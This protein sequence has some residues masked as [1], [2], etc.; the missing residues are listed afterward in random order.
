MIEREGD[1]IVLRGAVTVYELR[2][3]L[4]SGIAEIENGA[5]IVDLGALEQAD[6]SAIGM[7]IEW[8]RVSKRLGRELA[9]VN[10][11][12]GLASLIRLYGLNGV[13]P[14]EEAHR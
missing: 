1:R 11:G 5:K 4:G 14:V 13:I 2:R 9:F 3:L 10:P 8:M 7:F 6:S 12:P